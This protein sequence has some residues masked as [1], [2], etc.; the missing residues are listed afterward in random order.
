LDLR[1]YLPPAKMKTFRLWSKWILAVNG[2]AYVAA[3]IFFVTLRK[4]FQP[5]QWLA[6]LLLLLA[7]GTGLLIIPEQRYMI[8]PM[9]AAWVFFG[10]CLALLIA[11]RK[12]LLFKNV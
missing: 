6:P 11:R 1:R 8:A 10:A 9:V 4:N 5:L 2:T 3:L 7:V 12:K